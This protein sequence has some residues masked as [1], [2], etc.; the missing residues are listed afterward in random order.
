VAALLSLAVIGWSL[1]IRWYVARKTLGGRR[2]GGH[3]VL[4]AADLA[5]SIGG[6]F[7]I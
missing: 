4:V 7:L 3:C 5:L 6:S 2:H 1:F